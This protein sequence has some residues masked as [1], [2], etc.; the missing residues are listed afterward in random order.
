MKKIKTVCIYCGSKA[1]KNP[2]FEKSAKELG[3]F[4]AQ[5]NIAII[6]GGG[7]TGLMGAMASSALNH[8]GKVTGIIPQHLYDFE[9]KDKGGTDF[10]ITDLIITKDMHERKKMMYEKADAFITLSGSIGTLDET[11]EMITWR[12][13]KR[14]SKPIF[15]LNQDHYWQ[16]LFKILDHLISEEFTTKAT[17]EL[18]I[19][20]NSL[21]ELLQKL[22]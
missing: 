20:C 21:K 22:L 1:G 7:I 6:Y 18:Y 8:G 15:I 12:Q 13:L 19:R 11:I 14:H 2:E 10:K 3:K 9:L 17:K 4:L 5:N 16:P